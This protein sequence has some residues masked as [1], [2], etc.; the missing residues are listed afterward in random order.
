MQPS[1]Q[2]V[3][4]DVLTRFHRILVRE[5]G[6]R[7]PWDLTAPLTVVE[8]AKNLVPFEVHR[9][10]LGLETISDYEHVLLRLLAGQGGFLNLAPED[11]R[12]E[13]RKLLRSP[14]L[15]TGKYRDF[16]ADDVYLKKV[17]AT[18]ESAEEVNKDLPFFDDCPSCTEELPKEAAVNFC[19]FCGDDVRRVLCESCTRELRL[20]W[21][22]CVGCGMKV[23]PDDGH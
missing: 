11:R 12:E 21:R 18:M 7:Y 17:D 4:P 6:S 9:E 20:N 23:A 13:I 16:L 22:F 1:G 10:E 3:V 14:D 2:E 5:F 19:P 15:N 8:I